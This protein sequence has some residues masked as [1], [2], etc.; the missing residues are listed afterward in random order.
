MKYLQPPAIA[1]NGDNIGLLV[2]RETDTIKNI[3]VA[4]D[5]TM[6]VAKE[7]VKKKAN[8]IITHHPLLFHPVKNITDNSRVGEIVLFLIEHNINLYAAHTNLDSV[9]WG[10]NFALADSNT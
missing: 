4:L 7:A 2:G 3:L 9:Q 1:W 6:N 10:V 8:I 5:V